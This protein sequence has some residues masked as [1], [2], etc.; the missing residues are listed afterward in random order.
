MYSS[1]KQLKKAASM[2]D[3]TKRLVEEA[4]KMSTASSSK[5]DRIF[6][7]ERDSKTG[8]GFAIV[9]FMPPPPNEPSSFVK[10]VNHN[11]NYNGKYLN[12]NCPKHTPGVKRDCPICE[13]NRELWATEIEANKAIASLRKLKTSY[14]MNVYIVKNP[15]KPELEGKVMLY[16]CG[17]KIFEKIENARKEKYEGDTNIIEPFD[18]FDDGAN[19]RI[20]V[21]TIKDSKN[22]RDYPDYADST[23]ETK[24]ALLGGDDDKLEALWNQCYSL[25]E[26][27]SDDKFHSYEDIQK[28][29]NRVMSAKAPGY[30]NS[31]QQQEQEL[32]TLVNEVK[33]EDIMEELEAAYRNKTAVA[34]KSPSNVD[35]AVSAFQALA[36]EEIPF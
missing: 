32:N 17:V 22:N 27:V 4:E 34:A 28:N 12:E 35:D 19:F 23:F 25:Q 9:R 7:V 20:V 36:D 31:V 26:I 24:G 30:N 16:R 2:G 29:L 11:F 18:L 21:K 5:D 3:L 33:D 10:L 14:Y 8:N 1:F 13:S 15:A 6:S